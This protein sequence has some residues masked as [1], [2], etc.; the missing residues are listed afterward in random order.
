[1]NVCRLAFVGVILQLSGLSSLFAQPSN[2]SLQ[3]KE[4]ISGLN[5]IY[6]SEIGDNAQIYHGTEYIRNGTKWVH[7]PQA[8]L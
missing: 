7:R 3:Y 4:S 2:D 8:V 5:R 1:M 6:L